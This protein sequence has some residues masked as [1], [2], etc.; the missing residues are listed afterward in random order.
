MDYSR[1]FTPGQK[2]LL[3]PLSAVEGPARS[4]V[5]SAS[6]AGVGNS[7]IELTLPYRTAGDDIH[8]YLPGET[9]LVTSERHGMGVK[10]T[11]TLLRSSVPTLMRIEPNQDL[12]LFSRRLYPRVDTTAM[13]SCSRGKGTLSVS[14]AHWRGIVNEVRRRGVPASV[15]FRS[16]GINISAGG[17]SILFDLPAEV[18]ELYLILLRLQ[19]GA[20]LLC[21][22]SEVVWRE[23]VAGDGN[24][25][26]TGLRFIKIMDEDQQR[27]H[28]YVREELRRQG[29]DPD[30]AGGKRD[31]LRLM[32][33]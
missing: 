9:F 3:R 33:F 1:Y 7:Y 30:Q 17:I 14:R 4:E 26:S 19:E 32:Q 21:T 31:D 10:L 27:I 8:P 2:I 6:V 20:P 24:R 13:I 25:Q 12:E 5:V 18:G 22:L 28:E 15:P 11:G 16:M 23:A 29:S